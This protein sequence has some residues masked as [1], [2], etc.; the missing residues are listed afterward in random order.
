MATPQPP[1]EITPASPTLALPPSDTPAPA[2]PTAAPSLA[3]LLAPPGVDAAA[4]EGL[5]PALAELAQGAG[6]QFEVRPALSAADLQSQ[7]VRVVVTLP[8]D[9]GLASLA[10]AAPGVQFLALNIPGV[11]AGTNLSTIQAAGSRPDLQGF[12]AGYLAAAITTDW[13]V[14][15]LSEAGTGAGEAASQAFANGVVFYCGLCRPAYPPFPIPGYPLAAGLPAGASQADWQAAVDSF[16][17]WQVETVYVYSSA[18]NGDLM[19]FLANAG[20]RLIA[21]GAPPAGAGEQWV[22]SISGGDLLPAIGK[23]WPELVSGAGGQQVAL[24][25]AL[26]NVNPKLLSPG[27]QRLVENMLADLLD[28]FIDPGAVSTPTE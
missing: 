9:P 1:A 6:L 24:P 18:P 2:T 28:G 3:I 8:P 4:V 16:K 15:V 10:A 21:S 14:G 5:Q 12:L 27:R 26:E 11:Q 19:S 25:L 20:F 17:V 13:R 7:P 23:L 22:A